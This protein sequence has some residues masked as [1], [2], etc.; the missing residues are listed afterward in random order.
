LDYFFSNETFYGEFSIRD[1]FV[2]LI[3]FLKILLHGVLALGK[4]E[5]QSAGADVVPG[6]LRKTD[7]MQADDPYMTSLNLG[8]SVIPFF[9][10]FIAYFR[11]L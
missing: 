5:L 7:I 8:N 2:I 4:V 10:V 6:V 3:F 9:L 11:S 1:F